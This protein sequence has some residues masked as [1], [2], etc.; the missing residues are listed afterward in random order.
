VI[1]DPSPS[2][3][4]PRVKVY[5][6]GEIEPAFRGGAVR[7]VGNLGEIGS[8]YIEILLELIRRDERW[9]GIAIS[10]LFV[11][12]KYLDAVGSHEPGNAI[13]ATALAVLPK[14]LADPGGFHSFRCFL[15]TPP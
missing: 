11:S 10:G 4:S 1:T 7:Y 12:P 9:P 13:L 8:R 3:D 14:I 5:N 15:H 6:R 2:N